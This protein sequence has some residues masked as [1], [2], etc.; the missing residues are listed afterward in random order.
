MPIRDLSRSPRRIYIF[1]KSEDISAMKI[2][3]ISSCT[4][5]KKSKPHNQLIC[6]DFLENQN[7]R[8]KEEELKKYRCPA[9]EMYTGEHH[10]LTVKGMEFLW[11]KYGKE[12]VG[13]YILSAGYGLIPHDKIIAPYECTFKGMRINDIKDRSLRACLKN[14][15]LQSQL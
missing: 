2:L 4:G 3:V 10:I 12:N 11:G 6:S 7:L 8:K 9:I 14:R 15:I 1:K 13:F 5:E